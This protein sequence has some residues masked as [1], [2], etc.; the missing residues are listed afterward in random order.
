MNSFFYFIHLTSLVQLVQCVLTY[1]RS[2]LINYAY[3]T[4]PVIIDA[5]ERTSCWRYKDNSDV[6]RADIW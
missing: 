6:F 2:I 1:F 4:H 5:F 3:L